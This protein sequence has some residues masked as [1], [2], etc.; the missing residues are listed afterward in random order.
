[1][2]DELLYAPVVVCGCCGR[3]IPDLPGF[4]VFFGIL[5]YPADAG[6]GMCVGCLE[7]TEALFARPKEAV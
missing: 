5:P 3:L 2:D 1:L 4:N 7:F 6:Y